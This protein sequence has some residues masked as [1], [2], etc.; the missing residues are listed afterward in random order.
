MTAVAAKRKRLYRA[1]L[2]LAAAEARGVE[3]YHAAEPCRCA[4]PLS[5][6]AAEWD[7]NPPRRPH[8]IKCGHDR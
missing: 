2:A 6:A 4:Y 5:L 3:P 7:D 8:C 1:R